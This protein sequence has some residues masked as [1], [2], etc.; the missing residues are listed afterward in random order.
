MIGNPF[1][2]KGYVGP[3]Y[4]CDREK[5]TQDV[6]SLLRN[7]NNIALISQRRYGKTDLLRHCFSQP[8]IERD[9]YTFII[10]I[11]PTNSVVEMVNALGQSILNELKPK[12]KRAWERFVDILTSIRTGISF[13]ISGHPNWNIGIGELKNSDTTLKE[14]FEYLNHADHRCI[15]AIDE[16][17]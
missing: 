1:V 14:I 7:G 6:I 2:T 17:Q 13:D 9:Y 16:F 11:D 8:E 15:V 12:G 10:D 5:E 3:E 4:F